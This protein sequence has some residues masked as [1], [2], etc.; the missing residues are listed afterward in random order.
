MAKTKKQKQD[1]F[2]VRVKYVSNVSVRRIRNA[3]FGGLVTAW[4]LA[5]VQAVH[6]ASYICNDRGGFDYD[7]CNEPGWIIV[8]LIISAIGLVWWADVIPHIDYSLP[9][10]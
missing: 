10:D 8:W 9:V 1:S 7:R 4:L 6:L 2:T 3:L 5:G